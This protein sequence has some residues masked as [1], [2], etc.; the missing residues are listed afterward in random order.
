MDK[1]EQPTIVENRIVTIPNLLSLFRICLIPII[2]CL[3]FVEQCYFAAGCVLLLSGATDIVDGFIARKFNMISNLGKVLDPIADKLT[4][5]V[6]LVCLTVRF[7]QMLFPLALMICK[8]LAMLITGT[9][10]IR[11]T[12]FV[13]G[14]VWHGKIA[15]VLLYAMMVLHIF[16]P[17]IPASMS[18]VLVAA[19]TLMIGLSFALYLIRNIRLLRRSGSKDKERR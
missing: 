5:A 1:Q 15:T 19:S 9:W 11:R 12:G 3:Y 10:V 16:W 17:E 4:Q 14:A 2:V 13:P 6:M 7:P 18:T 8:E